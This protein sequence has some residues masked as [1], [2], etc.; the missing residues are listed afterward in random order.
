MSRRLLYPVLAL[1]AALLLSYGYTTTQKA[2][3][4]A[5]VAEIEASLMKTDQAALFS[6]IRQGYPA[7]YDAFLQEIAD[8][9]ASGTLDGDL[10]QSMFDKTQAFTTNLRRENA[11]YIRTAP[12]EAIRAMRQATLDVM[13]TL[14]DRPDAC[15]RF[16]LRGGNALQP[17][18]LSPAQMARINQAAELTFAALIAGRDQPV[19]NPPPQAGD[20]AAFL[21]AWR[22]AT[23][24][25][26]AVWAAL[27]SGNGAPADLCSAFVSMERYI[28][29]D[30]SPLST[31][32]LVDLTA[33]TVAN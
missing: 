8:L 22:A 20:R 11:Q 27:Q 12:L 32:M 17:G 33:Q 15:L 24:P 25:S 6:T 29:S 13:I 1:V 16:G 21:T 18:E 2:S 7:Q 23:T 31:R 19:T 28:L 14:Q 30:T 10:L 26:D 3:R 4:A 5:S 9:S